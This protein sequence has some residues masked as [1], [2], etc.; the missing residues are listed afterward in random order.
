MFFMQIK[1]KSQALT[2]A[3][4]DVASAVLLGHSQS[5]QQLL[6]ADTQPTQYLAICHSSAVW[7][8]PIEVV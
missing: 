3:R 6:E 4:T 8:K 1:S 2:L 5:K 7:A